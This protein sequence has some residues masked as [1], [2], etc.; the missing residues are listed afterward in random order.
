MAV[1]DGTSHNDTI[2]PTKLSSGV[3]P[4]VFPSNASDELHGHGGSD[5]L[6]GGGGNDTLDGGSGVDTLAGGAGND[7]YV[8]PAGDTISE[9]AGGGLDTVQSNAT[10]GALAAEVERLFLTGN[11]AINGTGNALA[12][13]IN[14]NTANNQLFGD[15]GNDTLSGGAGADTL[16]G[17]SGADRLVGGTQRDKFIPGVDSDVDTLVFNVLNDSTGQTRDVL[18]R[19]DFDED[20]IDLPTLPTAIAAAITVGVLSSATFNAN[21]AGAVN[22]VALPAGQAVLFDP[23]GGDLNQTGMVYLIVD[24]NGVAGYQANQDWV[25]QLENHTG[26]LDPTDFI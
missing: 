22:A 5:T 20:K 7:T 2:T 21:L 6:N 15:I 25:F 4:H 17:A 19:V 23:S 3:T 18:S 11:A 9:T 13:A 26:S 14:G 8:N 12:N 1:I 24:A 10:I 16:N